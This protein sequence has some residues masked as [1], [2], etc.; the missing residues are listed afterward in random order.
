M[1]HPTSYTEYFDKPDIEI[2]ESDILAFTCLRNEAMRIPYFLEFYRS[3]GVKKFFVIDNG[4]TDG[5]DALLKAAEDVAY[6]HTTGS[7]GGSGSSRDWTQELAYHYGRG[8]WCLTV[9]ADEILVYPGWEQFDLPQFCSYLE[10]EGTRGLFC[11]FL[12]MY[13]DKPISQT[14]YTPPEPFQDVCPYF[15]TETYRLHMSNLP[16]YLG[17]S[18]GPRWR[19]FWEAHPEKRGPSMR[20]VPLLKWDD[21]T[22][23]IY[24]THAHSDLPLS[25][26]TGVLMHFKFMSF[27]KDVVSEETSRG[28]RRLDT[29]Q[30][31]DYQR[32]SEVL[33]EDPNFI[34]PWSHRFKDS[35]DFVRHGLMRVTDNFRLFAKDYKSKSGGYET[36]SLGQA[37]GQ[38]LFDY[39][40]QNF[41]LSALAH[42]WP[43][44]NSGHEVHGI[45][46]RKYS[47]F[48]PWQRLAELERW[49]SI[50]DIKGDELIFQ[51]KEEAWEIAGDLDIEIVIR[52]DWDN[53]VHRISMQDLSDKL[54]RDTASLNANVFRR[55]LPKGAGHSLVTGNGVVTIALEAA[56]DSAS[57]PAKRVLQEIQMMGNPSKRYR[58][59]G[60]RIQAGTLEGWVFDCY[61]MNYAVPLV[62]Y[63]DDAFLCLHTPSRPWKSLETVAFSRRSAPGTARH[64]T[65]LGFGIALPGKLFENA[66]TVLDVK[67]QF[68]GFHLRNLPHSGLRTDMTLGQITQERPQQT[69]PAHKKVAS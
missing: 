36:S 49:V 32:Y 34:G 30:N 68:S 35:T 25:Q 65:G 55:R 9:D 11:T 28:D 37:Q 41:N 46:A 31:K 61:Q 3:R 50:F 63:A 24:S 66:G 51:V 57:K 12:D 22:R 33:K 15:E 62:V 17:M 1:Q 54:Q 26:L 13:S 14:A 58:G 45:L 2:G 8:H 53:V 40:S 60:Q 16:P 39:Q 47:R 43:Y 64:I 4:S 42:V 69:L 20:K 52:R 67:V 6:F 7:Y 23:Y 10:D 18:G 27:F 56:A 59:I 44:A 5:S 19:V 21:D 48:R 29:D 38:H